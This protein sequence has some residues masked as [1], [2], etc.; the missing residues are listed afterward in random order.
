MMCEIGV[1]RRR[2]EHPPVHA[3]ATFCGDDAQRF[4]KE[5]WPDRRHLI[6]VVWRH[7]HVE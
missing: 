3:T 6:A 5:L 2:F 7:D 4:V 1:H